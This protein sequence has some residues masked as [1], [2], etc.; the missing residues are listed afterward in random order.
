MRG[1]ESGALKGKPVAQVHCLSPPC[2]SPRCTTSPHTLAQEIKEDGSTDFLLQAEGE[3]EPRRVTATHGGSESGAGAEVGPGDSVE[4]DTIKT[5]NDFPEGAEA[6]E[7]LISLPHLHEPSILH[8]ISRRFARDDIYTA[9]GSVLL[10]VNPFRPLP[11]LYSSDTLQSYHT[12][13]LLTSSGGEVDAALPP[14]VYATAAAARAAMMNGDP[15]LGVVV[16]QSLLVS[17]E[18]GAGKTETTKI[19][20]RF[21]AAVGA[22]SSSGGHSDMHARVLQS[23]PI[24][25]AFGNAATLRNANSSRFGKYIELQHDVQGALVGAR[26]S[27]YLLERVRLVRV[28]S[29]ERTYHAFYQCL[30]GAPAEWKEAWGMP[31]SADECMALFKLVQ[32]SGTSALE[33]VDDAE[34]WAGT[35][36]AMSTMQ[37]AGDD[38][39]GMWRTVAALLWLGNVEFVA[40]PDG[41]DSSVVQSAGASG[42]AFV[43]ACD[44]LG[45][46]AAAL[47]DA[48]TSKTLVVVR[49]ST[50]KYFTPQG[51]ADA[52]DALIKALYGDL[53]ACIVSA[54]NARIRQDATTDSFIGV[55]DIFGFESFKSNSFEQ[56][57]INYANETLQQHFN[58][59]VFKAEQAEY[60]REGIDWTGI[61]FPDNAECLDLIQG[62]SPPGLLSLLDEACLMPR[63][64]DEGFARKCYEHLGKHPRLHVTSKQR[65]R[66]QFTVLHYAGQVVY[67][68]EGFCDKNKDRIH[69][70]AKEVVAASSNEFVAGL[71]GQEGTS[72]GDST[73]EYISRA[74]AEASTA[75]KA[76]GGTAGKSSA[77]AGGG[78]KRVKAGKGALSAPTVG[79]QFRGQLRT[80]LTIINATAPHYIRCLK[81]NASCSPRIIERPGLVAQLRCGGVLEAVRVSRV[82]YPVRF[83]HSVFAARYRALAAAAGCPALDATPDG[84][85]CM[86]EGLVSAARE[87]RHAPEAGHSASQRWRGAVAEAL[88]S[89]SPE[90]GPGKLEGLYQVGK[91]KVFFRQG[92]SEAL[93]AA[94]QRILAG[95]VLRVQGSMRTA[96]AARRWASMRRAVVTVQCAIRQAAARRALATARRERAAVKLQAWSRMLLACLAFARGRMAVVLLQAALRGST[97]RV[98]VQS[99][100]RN[101]AAARLQ[102]TARMWRQRGRW[103]A[104]QRCARALQNATRQR[105]AKQRLAALRQEARNVDNLKSTVAELRSALAAAQAQNGAL[106]QKLRSSEAAEAGE[107]QDAGEAVAGD[108]RIMPVDAPAAPVETTEDTADAGG[109]LAGLM[110]RAESVSL[111]G[112]PDLLKAL[113]VQLSVVS[114][115]QA[116]LAD[117]PPTAVQAAPPASPEVTGSLD[118]SASCPPST[119][120][121]TRESAGGAKHDVSPARGTPIHHT[122]SGDRAPSAPSSAPQQTRKAGLDWHQRY[123]AE[124]A[125]CASLRKER[126]RQVRALE[127]SLARLTSK[128]DSISRERDAAKEN[129]KLARLTLQARHGTPSIPRNP[130][131][132]TRSVIPRSPATYTTPAKRAVVLSHDVFSDDDSDEERPTKTAGMASPAHSR[133]RRGS[134]ASFATALEEAEVEGAPASPVLRAQGSS[135]HQKGAFAQATASA[136]TT[137]PEQGAARP[138]SIS[139][140]SSHIRNWFAGKAASPKHQTTLDLTSGHTS[141]RQVHGG[142]MQVDR[143]ARAVNGS[144]MAGGKVPIPASVAA[145]ALAAHVVGGQLGEASQ[146][147][148]QLRG[149]R[150]RHPTGSWP[151]TSPPPQ[152]SAVGPDTLVWVRGQEVALGDL[153]P[154]EREV[155]TA[156]LEQ[157]L[158]AQSLADVS[159]ELAET[160]LSLQ[161]AQAEKEELASRLRAMENAK[162]DIVAQLQRLGNVQALAAKLTRQEGGRQAAARAARRTHATGTVGV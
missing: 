34:E 9:C 107:R 75:R 102:A 66:H 138:R 93:E 99:M 132:S 131:K 20:M 85:A 162:Q 11:H 108:G 121:A 36:A 161:A 63:G 71:L 2:T 149:A 145:A 80:L 37:F 32:Q 94:R 153:P 115:V 49:E 60:R 139:N 90:G 113:G 129:L 40:G 152:L 76:M 52:R 57:C 24:L 5:A 72:S 26:I 134:A 141:T 47:Q 28:G 137:V 151:V 1:A 144:P 100:L 133:S 15:A 19:V 136:I 27:H 31:S 61:S 10:A 116:A 110:Q 64:S 82:G 128:V 4:F 101:K 79:T 21:L 114:E 140:F 51:A 38:V 123:Q 23:N 160:K 96:L 95:A 14:H 156:R 17:G 154:S 68:T 33:G 78:K 135:P 109:K 67:S 13:S 81:P 73:P 148:G 158:A 147:R 126:D 87:A 6:V 112:V 54:V 42:E 104:M 127:L 44:L 45:V 83:L 39:Q 118:T 86:L 29:G 119:P 43:K 55:L 159:A 143:L 8:V 142:G 50:K 105:A 41:P 69:P 46:E 77:G 70:E 103:T 92:S 91:S 146:A 84:C 65:A 120:P 7:D 117:Q 155:A 30:A 89:L 56:L 48:L 125:R 130:P 106:L 124:V 53:F 98:M 74:I 12:Y 22:S 59:F 25:E 16:N 97:A 122:P 88:A 62:R 18:S 111:S 58:Q 157:E 3:V 150:Q 35:L